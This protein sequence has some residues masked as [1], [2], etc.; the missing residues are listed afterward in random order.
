MKIDASLLPSSMRDYNT[1]DV[2]HC[3]RNANNLMKAL[4]KTLQL[5]DIDEVGVFE[6]IGKAHGWGGRQCWQ[7]RHHII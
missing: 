3:V 6:T 2:N 7:K 1:V 5:L 4:H